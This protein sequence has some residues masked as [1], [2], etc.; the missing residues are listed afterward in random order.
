M[1]NAGDLVVLQEYYL[2]SRLVLVERVTRKTAVVQ[3]VDYDRKTGGKSGKKSWSGFVDSSIRIATEDDLKSFRRHSIIHN[4][5]KNT[6]WDSL[7]DDQLN[8]VSEILVPL[9]LKQMVIRLSNGLRWLDNGSD[10]D[11]RVYEYDYNECRLIVKTDDEEEA[12]KSLLLGK[13]L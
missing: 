8:A 9:A 7:S 10:G 3:G 5:R 6:D 1:F 11:Y 13:K 2:P 12:R 4:L